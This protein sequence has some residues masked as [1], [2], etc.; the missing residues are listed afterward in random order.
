MSINNETKTFQS[1]AEVTGIEGDALEA[2]E[3]G[4]CRSNLA[5]GGKDLHEHWR[6]GRFSVVHSSVC[7][8]QFL[9]R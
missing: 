3:T 8:A 2:F 4:S 5:E 9:N 1:E 6:S 7:D